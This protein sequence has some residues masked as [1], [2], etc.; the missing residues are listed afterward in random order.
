MKLTEKKLRSM[1]I[2]EL[3]DDLDHTSLGDKIGHE[4][5]VK[6]ASSV[7]EDLLKKYISPSWIDWVYADPT[8][9]EY[10]FAIIDRQDSSKMTALGGKGRYNQP[11]RIPV[12]MGADS[13]PSAQL[14]KWML[15]AM[16]GGPDKMPT[17]IVAGVGEGNELKAK[18][19]KDIAA[20]NTEAAFK[21]VNPK[22][23]NLGFKDVV[24]NWNRLEGKLTE[25]KLR[26]MIR[27]CLSNYVRQ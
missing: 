17:V 2:S 26:E 9:S 16:K 27:D 13:Q 3:F 19:K 12:G 22:R 15:C 10:Y 5:A 11:R 6:Q 7:A 25:S 24:G 14:G 20:G 18:V 1:I 21:N 8:D 23:I 4:D